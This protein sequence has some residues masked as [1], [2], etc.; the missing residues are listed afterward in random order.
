MKTSLATVAVTITA[1]SLSLANPTPTP[2][3]TQPPCPVVTSRGICP[4]CITLACLEIS[5]L[6]QRCDCPTPVPT[7]IED[8]FCGEDGASA[9]CPT[10]K[11][12]STSY[13]IVEP[14]GCPKKGC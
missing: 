9:A 10:F 1:I 4:T 11:C 8:Y 6:T 7:L 3:T 14:T 5:T 2:T 12:G 13:T